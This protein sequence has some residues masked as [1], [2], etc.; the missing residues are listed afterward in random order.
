MADDV[1]ANAAGYQ[2][3]VTN[4][5]RISL[6]TDMVF[7]D[8]LAAREMATVTGSVT[9]GYSAHLTISVNA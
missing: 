7:S 1:Y 6:A 4:M 8:D 9:S 5:G 3:S 2:Q